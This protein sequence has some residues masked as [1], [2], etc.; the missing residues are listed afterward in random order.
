[1]YLN[2]D[3]GAHI[4]GFIAVVAHTLIVGASADNKAKGRQADVVLAAYNAVQTAL[5]LLKNGNSVSILL[6]FFIFKE[7]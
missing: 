5:R 2:S 7:I 3:L 1:M 4:D 6:L